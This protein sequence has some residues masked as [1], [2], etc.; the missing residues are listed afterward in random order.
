MIGDRAGR[1]GFE[2]FDDLVNVGDG[3]FVFVQELLSGVVGV[4]YTLS[5]S[6]RT[7]TPI[8]RFLLTMQI[9]WQLQRRHI[10][11]DI[12]IKHMIILHSL[13]H[14]LPPRPD[15][16]RHFPNLLPGRPGRGPLVGF[17][18]VAVLDHDDLTF[19]LA[20]STIT[21]HHPTII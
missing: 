2:E 19:A 4:F 16:I 11:R 8:I 9:I 5:L 1:V 6:A 18:F 17:R 7:P 12:H 15:S 21:N 14:L 13:I 10:L 3:E 20:C